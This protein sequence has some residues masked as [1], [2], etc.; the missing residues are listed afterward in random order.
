MA[1]DTSLFN[2]DGRQ[3]LLCWRDVL[4]KGAPLYVWWT[5]PC[6]NHV[7]LS[8]IHVTLSSKSLCQPCH[9]VSH[10]TLSSIHVTLSSK[11]LCQPC[12]SVNNTGVTHCSLLIGSFHRHVPI[13]MNEQLN[14]RTCKLYNLCRSNNICIGRVCTC[15]AVLSPPVSVCSMHTQLLQLPHTRLIY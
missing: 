8:S 4:C 11:S 3:A 1:G 14:T 12:H 15:A 13:W 7:T 2:W 10:A 9:S 6:L 5:Q